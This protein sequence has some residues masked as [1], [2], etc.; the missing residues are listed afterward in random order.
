MMS[1][2]NIL[3]R[4]QIKVMDLS[5]RS[6]NTHPWLSRPLPS[7]LKAKNKTGYERVRQWLEENNML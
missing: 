2:S 6:C 4:L 3:K 5:G 7:R 1:P